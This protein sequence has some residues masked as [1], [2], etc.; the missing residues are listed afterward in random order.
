MSKRILIVIVLA[1]FAVCAVAVAQQRKAID[2]ARL[3]KVE[4]KRT[5]SHVMKPARML[6]VPWHINYQGYLTDDAGNPIN[7]TLS[8]T[9]GIWDDPGA[10]SEL[11][12][13]NGNV[14]VEEGLFNVVLG[15]TTPIPSDV[16]GAGQSRWL[17]LTI[18]AQ[19]LS[20][21]TEIT[22]VGYAYRAVKADSAD[23]AGMVDGF[24]AS[25]TPGASDL[26]PLSAGDIQYVNE[27]QTD[28]ITSGMILD[29]TIVRGDA[30]AAF[31]APYA[32]T[33]D[34]AF[35]APVG[36]DNDWTITGSVLHP[37]ADYGLAMRSSNVLYGTNDSTHV[38][39]GI[40]CTTGMSGQ[41]YKYC[42]VS[43]GLSNSAGDWYATVGGGAGNV[44]SDWYATVGGGQNNTAS[45]NRGTVGGGESNVAS[46][47]FA[48]IAGGQ[49]NTASGSH[50]TV[51]GG[52]A[53]TTRAVYGAVLSGRHNIAGDQPE[54]TAAVVAGG[55]DNAA[56]AVYSSV[57]GGFGN[58]ASG[59]GA[60]VAGGAF[61]TATD[62]AATVG[63]GG[64]NT[65]NGSGATV[66][67]GAFNTAGSPG[68]TVS[69]GGYSS[70]SSYGATVAG[71]GYNAASGSWAT[72]GGGYADTVAGDYSFAAGNLVRV[73][74]AADY[75]FAFGRDFTTSTPNAVIFHNSVDPISVG[76]GTVSPTERLDVDGTVQMTGFSLPAGAATGYV[77]TS[78]ASGQG[79]WQ[80]AAG[81]NDWTITGSVLHPSSSYGLAMRSFNVLYGVYDTTHVNLGIACT[82][83]TSGQ[84]R[85]FCTVSGGYGNTAS[86]DYAAVGGGSGNTAGG[87][88]GTVSGGEKSSA[89]GQYAVVGGGRD[90]TASGNGAAIGGGGMNVVNG[91]WAAIG[92]GWDNAAA[93]NLAT[94][95]GGEQNTAGGQYATVGGGYA[96]TASGDYATVAG[97]DSNNAGGTGASVGGGRDNTASQLC[98]TIGGGQDNTASDLYTT[99]CGGLNN[100]ASGF[101]AT[102]G[103][104]W[105][106]IA[107]G[108]YA[109]VA[110]G[111]AD[112]V[113]GWHSFAAGRQVR[114]TADYTFGFGRNFTTSTANAV[115]FYHSPGPVRV[116]IGNTAPT[117]L[118][119][120]GTNGAYCNG[121]TWVDGSSREYK[122]QIVELTSE[123]AIEA[124]SRLTPVR[125]NYKSDKDETFV[126]FI[127]ED[128]PDLVATKDRKGVS[129]MD[130][131]AVLTKVVQ[132]QQERIE[133]LEAKIETMG[134]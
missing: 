127:A 28:A 133:A 9:F 121:F 101:G 117:H 120:V 16:F 34:Y 89:T 80:A 83:G 125:Y 130:I 73:A 129:P 14:V 51:G 59:S 41:N 54:D 103:G 39:L 86:Y 132:E 15:S 75:T 21:R 26:F 85:A 96:D 61:N 105:N 84:N 30:E 79:A 64:S 48:T 116:G 60:T 70:A 45:G 71:G 78:D 97:G 36:S 62:T 58:T 119:D 55:S 118:L 76:I 122:E 56:V 107:S 109:T 92:G 20:P 104:G 10:G 37:S 65:A 106:N 66:A 114:V 111:E 17:E 19:T 50:A 24:D 126:G 110:G 94:V 52:Y 4:V 23:D 46:A 77:L 102:V 134:K 1:A 98:T 90:N 93:G 91:D 11:W 74:G 100:T 12:N 128:V 18:V 40:A 7:D 131:V 99:V 88:H 67:G 2:G 5:E 13:E 31:K 87:Y 49:N 47:L 57:G 63:G 115:I 82:T 27:G 35:A 3:G 6:V 123:E 72:V 25:A 53:D 124:V 42:T 33:A 69:G 38:N 112:T 81:D 29:G 8:M 32:D 95:G 44:A 68:A 43:G 22:S 113:T 108:Y